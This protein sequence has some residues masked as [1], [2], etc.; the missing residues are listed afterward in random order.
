MDIRR[1]SLWEGRSATYLSNESFSTVIEDQGEI[2]LELSAL[3]KNGAR[4]SPLLLPYFRGTG[5]G[6]MSD[7]NGA[8]WRMRQGLYQCGGAYF[9]FPTN[10]EDKVTSNNTYWTVRRYGTENDYG[11]VWQYSEMKS[12]EAGNKYKISKVDMILPSQ[13][14]LYSAF[15]ITNTSSEELR[16]NPQYTAVLS[17][18]LI[19]PGAMIGVNAKSYYTC[20]MGKRESGVT[21]FIPSSTFLD[22]EKAPLREGGTASILSIPPSTGT[23]DY[24]LGTIEKTSDNIITVYNPLDGMCFFLL[25]RGETNED[26]FGFPFLT[27]GQNWRGRMDAPWALFDGATPQ[28][29]ALSVGFSYGESSKKEFVL[30][31]GETKATFIASGYAYLDTPRLS[32]KE[33]LSKEVKKEGIVLKKN[34]NS[35]L[36]PL[37]TS[38]KAIRKFSKKLFFMAQNE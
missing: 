7:E 15:A 5:S 10:D 37:D 38:F 3:N 36:I 25:S 11:G 28:V 12:R 14:V 27:L 2:T 33:Y 30:A 23:Y 34:K 19:E 17:D 16:C 13:N 6:V 32:I 29:S 35:T 31:P 8:W 20:P 22:P 26:E 21:R 9:S 4:V 18:P 1:L 24:I